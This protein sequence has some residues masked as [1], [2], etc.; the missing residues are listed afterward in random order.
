MTTHPRGVLERMLVPSVALGLRRRLAVPML[1][2]RTDPDARPGA[3]DHP[4]SL[5]VVLAAL[6]GSHDAET[7]LE[8]AV[9]VAGE[10]AHYVLLRVVSLPPQ[11]SSIYL[12][13]ATILYHQ[14]EEKLRA[15]AAEYLAALEDR[16]R[17]RLPHVE[18]RFGVHSQPGRLIVRAAEEVHADLVAVGSHGHGALRETL[19]GSVTSDV[20]RNCDVPVLVTHP[21][22][23]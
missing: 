2:V 1:F 15:E 17:A 8:E 10:S 19:F 18:K 3:S 23:G 16:L 6:D 7:A 9:G 14:D 11:L 4:A 21:R 5:N 12:P 20:L 22:Q 13:Q